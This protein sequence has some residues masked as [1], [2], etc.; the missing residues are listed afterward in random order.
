MKRIVIFVFIAFSFLSM[1]GQVTLKDTIELQIREGLPN[2]FSKAATNQPVKIGYFGGSIT[3]DPE[4]W[5]VKSLSWFIQYF[6]NNNITEFNAALGGTDSKYGVFRIEEHLLNKDNFDLIFIE[7]AINDNSSNVDEIDK[8][9]EGIVRK[10]WTKN[11]NTDICFVHTLR[12]GT[13]FDNVNDGK[14]PLTSTIH[15]NVAE[16]YG[17]PSVFCG[18]RV[19]ADINSGITVFEGTI[20]D[21]QNS[22][23]AQGKYVFTEDGVHPTNYGHELY[24]QIVSKC[25][26]LMEGIHTPSSHDLIL[27]MVTD[28]YEHASMNTYNQ[29]SNNGLETVTQQGDY[30]F[31]DNF[32][33]PENTFLLSE[34]QE[35]AYTFS[36]YG[37][38][39]GLSIIQGPGTGDGIIEVD[40]KASIINFFDPYSSYYRENSFFISADPDT[41]IVKIYPAAPLTLQQK[42]SI[43]L[44]DVQQDIQ[45]NPSKYQHNYIIFSKILVNGSIID[46]PLSGSGV[47]VT[48]DGYEFRVDRNTL[49]I[50]NPGEDGSPGVKAVSLLNLNG[51]IVYQHPVL[52]DMVRIDLTPLP[53]GLYIVRIRDRFTTEAFKISVL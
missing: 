32:I 26:R 48:A 20:T 44:P 52:A 34:N 24:T 3:E 42:E 12:N 7:F 39:L 6:G 36:F 16:H 15:D 18:V 19:I 47:T 38:I 30:T 9:I 13:M 50:E 43:L 45:Q 17:I 51:M 28:N 35:A 4:G 53:R 10:I 25:F 29:Q 41:H 27:P 40:G 1:Q 37:D 14:M 23:N 46:F 2:F 22:T 8:A 33:T 11:P 49:F 21:P 31:L 5:R